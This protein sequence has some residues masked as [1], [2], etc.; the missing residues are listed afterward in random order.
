MMNCYNQIR[1]GFHVILSAAK[2]LRRW[3]TIHAVTQILRCAQDDMGKWL[4]SRPRFPVLVVNG[5]HRVPT[6]NHCIADIDK[7]GHIDHGFSR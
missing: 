3:H 2:D 4:A 7:K 5:Q 6:E 1:Q